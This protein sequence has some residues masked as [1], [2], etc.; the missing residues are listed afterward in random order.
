MTKPISPELRKRRPWRLL[1]GE[2]GT[3]W[4]LVPEFAA[5]RMYSP[6][7]VNNIRSAICDLMD[8]LGRDPMIADLTDDN[9]VG[10]MQQM[11]RKG[12]APETINGSVGSLKTLWTWLAKR[13]LIEDFPTFQG[14]KEPK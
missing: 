11:R 2:R 6:R 8:V 14:V 7:H 1:S 5:E 4:Q 12:R 3:L 9:C 10:V 13:R